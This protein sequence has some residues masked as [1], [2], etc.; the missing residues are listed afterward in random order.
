M[1][2]GQARMH[3]ATREANRHLTTNE[4]TRTRARRTT[5]GQSEIRERECM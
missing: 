4:Q 5:D 2:G 3:V 1:I